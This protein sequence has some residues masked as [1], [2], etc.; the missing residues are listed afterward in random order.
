MQHD[1][2]FM[3]ITQKLTHHSSNCKYLVH[4]ISC[5]GFRRAHNKCDGLIMLQLHNVFLLWG[6]KAEIIQQEQKKVLA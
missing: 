2:Q 3:C 6:N 4:A 5:D 1:R